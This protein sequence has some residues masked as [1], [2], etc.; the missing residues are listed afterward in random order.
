MNTPQAASPLPPLL[1]EG[2]APDGLAKPVP[3]VPWL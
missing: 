3:W 2:G 1:R